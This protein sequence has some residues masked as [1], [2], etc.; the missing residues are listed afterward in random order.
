MTRD[1]AIN[2][3]NMISVA[4]VEPVT[5]EQRKLIYDTF[6]MA[7]KALDQ[8]PLEVEAAQ[9]QKAYNKGF[10]DCRQAVIDSLHNK[11]ADG[12]DSDRWWNSISVLYA[13]NKLPSVK[14]EPKTDNDLDMKLKL[15]EA[16]INGYTQGLKDA[17]NTEQEPKAEQF[18]E[19]VAT[20]IFDENWEYNKDA[21]EELACRKLAKLGI[22]RANGGE[23]ELVEPH[24]SEDKE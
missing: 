4:F 21:F 23:W 16:N 11:F 10:E 24:E 1:E 19:W 2:N 17:S 13:I 7:I 15:M 20:E 5:K 3:L 14:Q 6:D 18:A 8:E 9:L 22:V 12:F